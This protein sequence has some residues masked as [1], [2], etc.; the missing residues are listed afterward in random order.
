MVNS[1]WVSGKFCVPELPACKSLIFFSSN[2]GR[3]CLA[4]GM[5]GSSLNSADVR[6]TASGGWHQVHAGT[7]LRQGVELTRTWYSPSRR[8]RVSMHDKHQSSQEQSRYS[9]RQRYA[10]YLTLPLLTIRDRGITAQRWGPMSI[11]EWIPSWPHNNIVLTFRGWSILR[12]RNLFRIYS[13]FRAFSIDLMLYKHVPSP[14]SCVP[15]FIFLPLSHT[16]S[17]LSS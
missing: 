10:P 8:G 15:V 1:D 3:L 5:V 16:V 11:P 17:F 6:G 2:G 14:F 13:E 9:S 12:H 4:G 7:T